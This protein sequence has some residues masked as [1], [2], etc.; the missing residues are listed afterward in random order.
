M[1][2]PTAAPSMPSTS[3]TDPF[4]FGNAVAADEALAHFD[5]VDVAEVGE[6]HDAKGEDDQAR[7]PRGGTI[8]TA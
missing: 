2:M 3:V 5:P 1:L 8:R 4:R 7:S 6:H